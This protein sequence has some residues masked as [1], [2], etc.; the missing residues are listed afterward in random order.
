[1]RATFGGEKWFKDSRQQ[2]GRDA[3]TAI[4]D[5]HTDVRSSSQL[6][7]AILRTLGQVHVACLDSYAPVTGDGLVSVFENLHERLLHFCFVESGRKGVSLEPE[8]PLHRRGSRVL[9]KEF[10][11]TLQDLVEVARS[12]AAS[13]LFLTAE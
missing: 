3:A 2:F 12:L 8:L 7:I 4:I 1:M 6:D 9:L 5:F 11:C 10:H 13:L